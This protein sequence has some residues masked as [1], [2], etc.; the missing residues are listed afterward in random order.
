M[1]AIINLW[2]SLKCGILIEQLKTS[3]ILRRGSDPWNY[4]LSYFD[5]L[6]L[7]NGANRLSP[8]V[9]K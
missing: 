5:C 1:N 6:K 7:E 2:V 9:G 8:K 4:L 3:Y